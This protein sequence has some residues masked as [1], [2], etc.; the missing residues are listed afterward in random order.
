VKMYSVFTKHW[1][2]AFL[3]H[4]SKWL[5]GEKA[6]RAIT[7]CERSGA[8]TPQRDAP[9]V[10]PTTA[11]LDTAERKGF[12]LAVI[13]RS[14]AIMIIGLAYL[15]YLQAPANIYAFSGTVGITLI[16]LT[17]LFAVGTRYEKT[18]RFILFGFDTAI[19]TALLAFV[20]LS[21]GGQ[22][23]QNLVF[24]TARVQYYYIMIAA[25]MLTL[26]PKLVIWAGL[27]SVCGLAGATGWIL[28]GMAVITARDIGAAPSLQI[29]H[30]TVLNPGVIALT[31]R[32][33]D[34]LVLTAVTAIV[35]W[36]VHRARE[37]VRAHAGAEAERQRLETL[38]G[39]YV[40]ATVLRELIKEGHLAPQMRNATLLFIDIEGFTSISE[41]MPPAQLVRLLNGLFSAV[42]AVVDQN[43]GVVINYIGD[44]IIA[45]FNA[46]L[47]ASEPAA[48]AIETSRRVLDL[49]SRRKFEGLTMHL[50]I[51]IA[52]GPVAAGTV[53]SGRRQTYTLYGDAV[54]LAQRL[55]VMNK[56]FG[57]RCLVCGETA[58]LAN[59]ARSGLH[60][61]G[62]VPIR[63]RNQPIEVF[64]LL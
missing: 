45:S 24:M 62:H 51:G 22:V 35:A 43:G 58:R 59:P 18:A 57:T 3:E 34:A 49:V 6:R 27:C 21:D 26:S 4:P 42:T 63:S 31:L 53:G 10:E 33:Q 30:D 15:I 48:R 46:P 16:G 37:V 8:A 44:A 56:D 7:K 32:M 11:A 28:N 52:S 47:P 64:K 55:E 17:S 9:S 20:P 14:L 41:S 29:F 39:R 23:P 19:I 1:N 40:P 61:L 13:A 36:G 5:N 60:S 25:A 50:R 38:F 12:R 2:S 54:N